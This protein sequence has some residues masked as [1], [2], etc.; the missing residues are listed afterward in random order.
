VTVDQAISGIVIVLYVI[1][2]LLVLS[3]ADI[4]SRTAPNSYLVGGGS[5]GILIEIA[6]GVEPEIILRVISLAFTMTLVLS[7]YRIG[8]V[9]GGDVKTLIVVALLSPGLPTMTC[10]DEVLEAVLAG[11][12]ELFVMLLLG[13]IHSRF[14]SDGGRTS[15]ITPLIPYLLV[16]Y[17]VVQ[18]ASI[19]C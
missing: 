6:M 13:T 7:L 10:D 19:L 14:R 8:A 3:V 11:G 5:I 17:L 16:G 15:E 1:L 12:I 9:G 18:I 4:R 2:L